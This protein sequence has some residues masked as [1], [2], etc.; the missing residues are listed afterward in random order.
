[1]PAQSNVPPEPDDPPRRRANKRP[2]HGSYDNDRPPI[3]H[4]ISRESGEE[5]CWVV[6]HSDKLTCQGIFAQAIP[7]DQTIVYSDAYRSYHGISQQHATVNH[8]QHEW[9]RDDDGDGVRQVHCNSFE[10]A[11]AG[12]RTLVR[13][14]RGIHTVY[15]HY[16]VAKDEA[17]V[18]AKRVSPALIC[19][20][21]WPPKQP[22]HAYWT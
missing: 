11:G 17:L 14:F 3:I 12:L 21:C 22:P 20:L 16:Y 7:A 8:S 4:V 19:P 15:L 18:N 1:V 5:R 10:G 9:A 2:G 6:A 13:P